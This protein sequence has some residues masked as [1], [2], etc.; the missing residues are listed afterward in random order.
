MNRANR[1]LGYSLTSSGRLGGT[2]ADPKVI[3]QIALKSN[4]LA[5]ILAHNHHSGNSKPSDMDIVLT[6]RPR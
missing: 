4:S 6:K 5:I 1:V 3:F 2:I